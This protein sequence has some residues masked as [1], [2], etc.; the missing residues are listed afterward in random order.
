[1]A[2]S[3]STS[4]ARAAADIGADL[5]VSVMSAAKRGFRFTTAKDKTAARVRTGVFMGL[6]TIRGAREWGNEFPNQGRDAA[7]RHHRRVPAAE[8][9]AGDVGKPPPHVAPLLR[10][11][12]GAARPS[13]PIARNF[14][15]RPLFTQ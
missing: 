2:K 8:R 4:V 15:R 1:M 9:T 7:L 6:A 10:G 3:P 13:L 14:F 12:D 5:S 11:A